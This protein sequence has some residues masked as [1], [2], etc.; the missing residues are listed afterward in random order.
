MLT[1]EG[2]RTRQARF[3]AA[4]DAAGIP[5]AVISDPR[6]IY[7][8]T[9]VL[10]ENK[11]FPYPNLL[12][13]GPGLGSWLATGLADGEAEVDD[14]H[15][16][17]IQVNATLNP[18]NHRRLAPLVSGLAGRNHDLARLGFQREALPYSLQQTF[19]AAASPREWVEVDDLLQDLQLRKDPD[20]VDCIQVAIGAVLAGYSRAQQVIQAGASELEIMTECQ[21]A[22]QRHTGEVHFYNGDFRSGE[23]GGFARDRRIEAGELYI[24]DAWADVHGYWCDMSRAWAVSGEPTDLQAS[25]YEHVAE[26][27]RAVPEMA[28][29]GRDTRDLWSELDARIRRHPHLAQNGLVHH[30]GHGIGLRVHEMPDLNRERGGVFEV[31]NVFTCEPGAYS[32]EL[33]GGV[34]L[35]N[36]FLVTEAGT[37]ALSDY[38]LSVVPDP[39]CPVPGKRES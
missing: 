20:E 6:D 7:Y 9:G 21:A 23:P 4:L 19:H 38:P 3:L 39:Q 35:E 30:G 22:A 1:R 29:V 26:I 2:C 10:P 8:L 28:V 5:A 37:V 25:V 16:Y 33:R 36:V 12:F 13:I 18:D 15:V 11:M 14:R 17:P 34:R 27:L 32:E 24:I 31:G